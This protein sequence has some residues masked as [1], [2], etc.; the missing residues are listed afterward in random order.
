[1]YNMAL[2]LPDSSIASQLATL[3][4]QV[5]N[6]IETV[7][8]LKSNDVKILDKLDKMSEGKTSD[9]EKIVRLQE[10]VEVLQKIVYG[11]VGIALAALITAMMQL[12]TVK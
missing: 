6:I 9:M 10:R 7:D 4:Q 1:M 12:V 5:K 8:T 2:N 11:A 3:E